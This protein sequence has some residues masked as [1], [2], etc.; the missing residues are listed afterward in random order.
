MPADAQPLQRWLNQQPRTVRELLSRAGHLAAINREL[1]QQW[2][3]EPWIQSI[4]IANIRGNTVVIFAQTATALVPL[5]YRKEAL[6][7][8][9]KERFQLAC[10]EI[11][12]KVRPE[13]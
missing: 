1:Q 10:K 13:F 2:A 6:L 12:A 3:S 4:R 11:D 7:S 8:F 9:L 5:R